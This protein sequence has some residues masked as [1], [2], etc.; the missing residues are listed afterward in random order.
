MKKY[1]INQF[2][3]KD[4]Y[5]LGVEFTNTK[6]K[7]SCFKKA[8]ALDPLHGPAWHS[9]GVL[10]CFKGDVRMQ[11]FCNT[12]AV[13][14]YK[15]GL[16]RFR[17]K[18]TKAEWM[19]QI[20]NKKDDTREQ[21]IIPL[22]TYDVIAVIDEEID[23]I[24]ENLGRLYGNMNN[25]SGAAECYDNLIEV[26]PNWV[27]PHKARGI[28]HYR[29]ENHRKAV[30]DLRFVIEVND[31]DYVSYYFLGMSYS[32]M[33]QDERAK[34]Y[35]RKAIN[36]AD[37]FPNNIE[38]KEI[39]AD[40]CFELENYDESIK[41]YMEIL[42]QSPKDKFILNKLANAHLESGK[43]KQAKRFYEKACKIQ[44]QENRTNGGIA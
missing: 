41:G 19:A 42:K 23:D 24:L 2:R 18:L 39:R 40:C 11:N 8:V 33:G 26:Y 12:K 37:R 34:W 13:E 36:V 27:R 6:K 28:I 43:N 4:W 22:S 29:L 9:L 31:S 20:K 3:A 5:H 44:E 14:A 25:L 30:D 15:S 1:D 21:M 17:R 35:F 10:Y 16:R 32:E 7:I 38:A